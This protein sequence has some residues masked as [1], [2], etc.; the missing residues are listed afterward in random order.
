MVAV[1]GDVERPGAAEYQVDV[2]GHEAEFQFG[3]LARGRFL[4]MVGPGPGQP[5][6][7]QRKRRGEPV[8]RRRVVEHLRWVEVLELVVAE[9]GFRAHL[10]GRGDRKSTRL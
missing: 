8:V 2:L 10:A 9:V 7:P 5:E 3:A 1:D 6:R 4:G